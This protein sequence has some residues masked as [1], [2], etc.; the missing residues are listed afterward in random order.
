MRRFWI[1]SGV[2]G[3]TESLERLNAA[4][5]MRRPD[6]I[7]FAG[8]I[9]SP[10]R[11]CAVKMVPWC[12]AEPD[13]AFVEKFLAALN[14]LGV[15]SAVIP[16]PQGEP[17]EEFLR[18]AM[19]AEVMFPHVHVVHLTHVEVRDVALCGIGGVLS[20]EALCGVDTCT[21]T[22][23]EYCVDCGARIGHARSCCWRRLRRARS[24]GR[25]DC[26]W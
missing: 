20:E 3:Q 2:D 25:G 24:V 5:E 4:V 9:V 23:A 14:G 1:C 6:A 17:R 26:R 19:W 16:G 11:H 8:G 21:R 22:M 7:L 13:A 12:L 15:F 10:T 18:L